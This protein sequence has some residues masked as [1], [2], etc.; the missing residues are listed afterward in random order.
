MRNLPLD[1][2]RPLKPSDFDIN[3]LD[4]LVPKQVLAFLQLLIS[5][6][7]SVSSRI[8]LVANSMGQDLIFAIYR[9]RQKTPKH[10]LLSY[11]VKTLTGNIE[12]IKKH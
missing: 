7:A 6:N 10:F 1:T 5:G 3:N 8:N 4:S 9:G 11:G 12:L 2:T